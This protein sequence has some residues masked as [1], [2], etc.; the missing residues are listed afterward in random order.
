[1]NRL[2]FG[3]GIILSL[4]AFVPQGQLFAESQSLSVTPPLFQLSVGPGDIWQSSVRVVNTNQFPLTVYAEVVNFLPDG[5]GGQGKFMPVLR[6]D[7]T[8]A[9]LAEWIEAP[10]GPHTIP[11]G[12]TKE[13]PFFVDVPTD[14]APGG[15]FAAIL[16]STERPKS[17]GGPLA[18]VTT[19]TVASLFFTRIEGDITELATIREFSVARR[20][21]E[22]PAAEFSLR[23]ENKGN[24]H[25]QPRGN[26]VITNM[27]GTER[28]FIP[29]NLDTMFGNVLPGSIR[30]FRFTWKGE[31]SLTDIGRYKAIATLGYGE[32]GVKSATATTYF[33]VLPIKGALV[34]VLSLLAIIGAIVWMIRLYVRRMLLLAGVNP[35]APQYPQVEGDTVNERMRKIPSVAVTAPIREGTIDLRARLSEAHESSEIITT[36][37][38]FVF[39]YR[40]FF[41]ALIL[42]I[43]TALGI[44]LYAREVSNQD[45]SYEVTIDEGE[46]ERTITTGNRTDEEP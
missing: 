12:Q 5:E 41:I 6:E 24:V 28:G 21:I 45:T 19:Q 37:T 44:Y 40:R 26:I 18:L 13:I 42:L 36:I 14:A 35:D 30:D 3:I 38:G 9:T 39:Q 10:V 11:A 17:E 27:W 16:V 22:L 23:F 20:S 7:D 33:W 2:S 32:D 31:R 8:R 15:H 34:T 25:V 29:V 46:T 4:L 1:M 43:L